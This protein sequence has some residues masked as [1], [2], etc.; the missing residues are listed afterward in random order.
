MFTRLMLLVITMETMLHASVRVYYF[1]TTIPQRDGSLLAEKQFF[2]DD[3]EKNE[4]SFVCRIF[5]HNRMKKFTLGIPSLSYEAEMAA[6]ER[7]NPCYHCNYY[8]QTLADSF[9]YS[10]NIDK[11][12]E[13]QLLHESV[14]RAQDIIYYRKKYEEYNESNDKSALNTLKEMEL[15]MT[16]RPNPFILE[17]VVKQ[18][19]SIMQQAHFEAQEKKA[20][21]KSLEG[22]DSFA[23]LRSH[24]P[25]DLSNP[26]CED[27]DLEVIV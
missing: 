3:D 6:Y 13:E 19:L 17:V 21:R 12:S 22:G 23:F 26:L 2:L 4:H 24:E 18:L 14:Q 7:Q 16:T 25:K 9:L 15:K 20:R 27:D 1:D 11:L 8:S 10:Y 5:Q